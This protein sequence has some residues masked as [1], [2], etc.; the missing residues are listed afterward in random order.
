MN[1]PA[2]APYNDAIAQ[3]QKKW[4]GLLK[5][6]SHKELFEDLRPTA[7]G[8]KVGT[9]AEH[10]EIVATWRDEGDQLHSKWMNGRWITVMYLREDKHF[11][12][13]IRTL[14]ILQR[15]PGA[16]DKLGLDHIDFYSPK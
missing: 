4:A 3:Y 16:S 11:A 15:R 6:A 7:L 8:W 5:Q 12:W 2:A 10:D 1:N 14:K 13:G 9:L